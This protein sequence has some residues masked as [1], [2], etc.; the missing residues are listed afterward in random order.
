MFNIIII[1][2]L[3]NLIFI[4]Q[5]YFSKAI[6]YLP[7]IALQRSNINSTYTYCTCLIYF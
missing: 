5:L 4:Y 1:I 3:L 7:K 6:I 2:I